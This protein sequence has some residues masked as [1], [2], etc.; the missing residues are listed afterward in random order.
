[1]KNLLAAAL[2]AVLV[3]PAAAAAQ[4]A[5]GTVGA[6]ATILAYLDVQTVEDVD[7]GSVNAGAAAALTPGTVPGAGTL[8]VL[9]MDHNSDVSVSVSLPA[10]GLSLVGG[11]GGEPNLPVSFDCGYSSA[12]SGVLDGAAVGCASLA[13]RS[14]NADG[15]SR[16]SYIQVGGSIDA[17]DTAGRLPGTY[18]GQLVFT[19]TAIY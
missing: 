7:F 3:L 6:S 18:T 19:V 12:S 8:G 16:T 17:G 15:S 13:N 14:G 11:G 4:S 5:N 2:A 9:Q 1:V 10:G